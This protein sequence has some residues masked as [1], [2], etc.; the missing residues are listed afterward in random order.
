M[1]PNRVKHHNGHLLEITHIIFL[2]KKWEKPE[3]QKFDFGFLNEGTKF[4]NLAIF[5]QENWRLVSNFDSP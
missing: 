2:V 1:V 3:Q 4:K 5:Q